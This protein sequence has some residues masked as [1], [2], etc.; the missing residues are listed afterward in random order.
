MRK[1]SKILTVL[2]TLILLVGV[3][4]SVV[5]SA[6]SESRETLNI[7]K[8]SKN[9]YTDFES[10]QTNGNHYIRFF[11]GEY[12][13]S[14]SNSFQVEYPTVSGNTYA[15]YS[16][17]GNNT[18]ASATVAAVALIMPDYKNAS[19]L[20]G[21]E[22]GSNNMGAYDY[23]VLDFEMASDKYTFTFTADVKTSYT[24]GNGAPTVTNVTGK[25]VCNGAKPLGR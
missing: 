23:A 24:K 6:E 17:K 5:A 14:T 12:S 25:A 8:S 11:V 21:N 16:S 4:L 1:S 18:L 15:R 10:K 22:T 7:T 3:V 13:S 2:L 9:L 20:V 19:Y